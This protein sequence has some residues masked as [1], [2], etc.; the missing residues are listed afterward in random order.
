MYFAME[1]LQQESAT[2]HHR[3]CNCIFKARSFTYRLSRSPILGLE[4][5]TRQTT[6]MCVSTDWIVEADRGIYLSSMQSSNRQRAKD[7][8]KARLGIV[9]LCRMHQAQSGVTRLI[10]HALRHEPCPRTARS[11]PQLIACISLRYTTFPS[12][13]KDTPRLKHSEVVRHMSLLSRPCI[14]T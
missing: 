10:S 7:W 4:V 8:R 3:D 11:A 9:L 14:V 2:S 13:L 1:I 5:D 12:I 6:D